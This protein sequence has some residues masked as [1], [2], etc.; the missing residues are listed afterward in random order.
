MKEGKEQKQKMVVFNESNVM[1]A[2][3]DCLISMIR[4]LSTQHRQSNLEYI[5]AGNDLWQTH[6]ELTNI[7]PTIEIYPMIG[8]DHMIE[9]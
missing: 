1:S 3:I 4:K 9:T 6:D 7:I 5:R 8:A 2:K